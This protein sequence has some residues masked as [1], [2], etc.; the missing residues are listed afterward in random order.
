MSRI[1]P[2]NIQGPL[3]SAR[4]AFQQGEI[5][6][7]IQICDER[8][9]KNRRDPNALLL[10]GRCLTLGGLNEMASTH[11]KLALELMPKHPG[12]HI[13]LGQLDAALG[14][15]QGALSRFSKALELR[16]DSEEAALERGQL[17]ERLGKHEEALADLRTITPESGLFDAASRAIGLLQLHTGELEAAIQSTQEIMNRTPAGNLLHREAALIQGRVHD[18][19]GDTDKAMELWI[20]GNDD[21]KTA[22]D[23]KEFT[24]RINAL[25]RIYP[26]TN[27][28]DLEKSTCESKLPVFIVGMPRSGTTLV[29]QILGSHDLIHSAGEIRHIESLSSSLPRRLGSKAKMPH[30]LLELNTE[31][32]DSLSKIYLGDLEKINNGNSLRVLNK[33]LEN[34]WSVGLLHQMYPNAKFI[35]VSRNP[36]D[37]AISVYSNSFNT[38]KFSYAYTQNLGDI[39]FVYCEINKLMSHWAQIFPDAV[40]QVK[41]ED[42]LNEPEEQARRMVDHL[43]LQWNA[44]CLNFHQ[45]RR[46]VLTLSYSQVNRPIYLS[47]QDRWKP[48]EK[49]LGELQKA[50]QDNSP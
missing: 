34:Y 49:H 30:C 13:A 6:K 25:I 37:I 21:P 35:F 38:K 40:L 2:R 4:Q 50:L 42:I 29:E 5:L 27:I 43:G 7:A 39:G 11:L 17:L 10:K 8:L 15:P 16:P 19:L 20:K 9:S 31:S 23:H 47:S 3:H 46:L 33:S 32:L 18:K 26:E 45:N 1:P 22:F 48:Y 44:K 12:V 14:N 24:E 41:Y 36:M 28:N